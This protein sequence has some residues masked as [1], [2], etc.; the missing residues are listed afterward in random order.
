MIGVAM[1]RD[2]VIHITNEQ[3][4]LADLVADPTPS[5]VALICRNVRTLGGKKPVFIDSVDSVFVIPLAQVR[6][7]EMPKAS[8]AANDVERE[9][10]ASQEQASALEAEY[11]AGPLARLAW[12]T[13]GSEGPVAGRFS[14]DDSVGSADPDEIDPHLLR[15]VRD[16]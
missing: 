5:D 9:A 10:K 6:L 2:V 14:M 12:L 1:L 16:A 8:V 13:G 15:R 3:P 7:V 4:I 11:A